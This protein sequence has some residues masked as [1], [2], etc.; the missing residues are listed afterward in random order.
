VANNTLS[1]RSAT[2]ETTSCLLAL[3]RDFLPGASKGT[4]KWIKGT[5]RKSSVFFSNNKCLYKCV[6][7]FISEKKKNNI[8]RKALLVF[9]GQCGAFHQTG[10]NW[11]RDPHNESNNIYSSN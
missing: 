11:S 10:G 3:S 6:Q 2:E 8:G 5:W 9:L 7:Y 4:E 1:S